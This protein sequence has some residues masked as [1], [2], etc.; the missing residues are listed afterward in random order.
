[1][2]LPVTE[3][4]N[5]ALLQKYKP[6][7]ETPMQAAFIKEQALVEAMRQLDLKSYSYIKKI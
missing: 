7:T 3:D 5:D 6:S 4:R 1:M 2:L